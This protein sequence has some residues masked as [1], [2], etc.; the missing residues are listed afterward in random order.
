MSTQE[1]KRA[2]AA[3]GFDGWQTK[4]TKGNKSQRQQQLRKVFIVASD[5]KH[6][7]LKGSVMVTDG[8]ARLGL[9]GLGGG[10]G[11]TDSTRKSPHLC[12]CRATATSLNLL[13][14][15][16]ITHQ[17]ESIIND[18]SKRVLHSELHVCFYPDFIR[19]R[20]IILSLLV[21][22]PSE[23]PNF[24]AALSLFLWHCLVYAVILAPRDGSL[25]LSS[26]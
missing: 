16:K 10:A 22:Q 2:A 13:Q 23:G 4:A 6:V 9:T 3:I 11:V 8:A 19:K 15:K 7:G 20:C 24:M 21:P 17:L 1:R 5:Q 26:L 25:P 14:L 12:S 18:E